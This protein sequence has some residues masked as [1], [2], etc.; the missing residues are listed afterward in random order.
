MEDP[1]VDRLHRLDRLLPFELE[2][3]LARLH[4]VA[5]RL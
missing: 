2:E 5:R 3:G 4:P 1:T